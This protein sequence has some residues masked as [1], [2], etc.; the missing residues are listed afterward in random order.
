[1]VFNCFYT[2]LTHEVAP[3]QP[4]PF[5]DATIPVTMIGVTCMIISWNVVAAAGLLG[6]ESMDFPG[7]EENSLR[8]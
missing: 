8:M 6:M 1:M 5:T 7:M 2:Y 4:L 3:W